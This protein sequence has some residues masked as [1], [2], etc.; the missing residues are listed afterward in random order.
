MQ[1][2][3]LHI[4]D[5]H[6][7]YEQY[8]SVER[9][10]D[11]GQAFYEAIK[12]AKDSDVDFVL[13]SGDLFNKRSVNP[14]TLLQATY[15]LK[16]LK[17]MDIPVICVE[18]NHDRAHFSDEVSWMNYLAREG[19][20]KLLNPEIR[21]GKVLITPWDEKKA[22]GAYYEIDGVR[23]YGIKYY[24]S[25]TEAVLREFIKNVE[26]SDRFSILMMHTAIEG[27]IPG[28]AGVISYS[29]LSELR[30][31]INYVALG[32]VHKFYT[33]DDWVYNPGSLETWS[34]D[35][36]RWK[37][38]FI[39][40]VVKDG[41]I[42]AE[43]IEN[44]RRKF[45]RLNFD[46]K[47][48][49]SYRD[50]EIFMAKNRVE[51]NPVVELTVDGYRDEIDESRIKKM[52]ERI[53]DPVVVNIRIRD[54]GG[55]YDISVEDVGGD[56][57]K[58]IIEELTRSRKLLGPMYHSTEFILELKEIF[59]SPF[60]PEIVDR[61]I[62]QFLMSFTGNESSRQPSVKVEGEPETENG[63]AEVWD[64]RRAY[65]KRG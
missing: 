38:G 58:T 2:S 3:F 32:H 8:G 6:L 50:L 42:R 23:I 17:E 31:R 25:S 27:Y 33:V 63:D 59:T 20:I 28:N 18:G 22:R 30:D 44:R 19:F 9:F 34:V 21:D 35:E 14:K 39:H 36:Y 37:K 48:E 65:D 41:K 53:F 51:G 52:V 11:F 26:P 64:W 54:V 7:G 15:A 61:R 45:V 24:G 43:L 4:A 47:G 16:M 13:I 1:F 40:A 57:E 55:R 10:L 46:F 12:Y 56:I 29:T 49:E 60:N 62:E 5:V